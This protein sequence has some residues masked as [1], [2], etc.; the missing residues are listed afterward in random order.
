MTAVT[1]SGEPRARPIRPT[2]EPEAAPV[3]LAESANP[4]LRT[5]VVAFATG[6]ATE[7]WD[8]TRL[9]R[10]VIAR[11]GV[12]SGQVTITTPH[13]TTTI[14][15]NEVETGFLNDARRMIAA[16]VPDG[17]YYEHDD[18]EVRTENLRDDE[19]LNGH[20]HCRALVVGQ[21]SVTIPVVDGEV[22]LGRWQRVMFVELDQARERRAVV[23][24]QGV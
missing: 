24:V 4:R 17:I 3:V 11:S 10:S 5:E 12:R 19:Y 20:A 2:R 22:L 14:V 1:R 18:H 7:F 6:A 16:H 9:V 15:V 23:H 8:L 13:T 21:P